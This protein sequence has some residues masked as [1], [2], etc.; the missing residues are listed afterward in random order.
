M[1]ITVRWTLCW[2][3]PRHQR[4][5]A[6]KP[7]VGLEPTTPSLPWKGK[8]VIGGTRRHERATKVLLFDPFLIRVASH[9]FRVVPSGSCAH[10]APCPGPAIRACGH[11]GCLV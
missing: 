4:Q 2:A 7:S 1:S 8:G 6:R 5:P 11:S 3:I 10:V 9:S